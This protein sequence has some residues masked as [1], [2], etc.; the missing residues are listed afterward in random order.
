MPATMSESSTPTTHAP[1]IAFVGGGSGGH[2]SPGLAIDEALRARSATVR[3]VFI[4][5]DRA[6]DET[7]LGAA[8]AARFPV[9]ARPPSIRP[10]AAWRFVRAWST[11]RSRVTDILR[12][13]SATAVVALGGFVAAPA[14]AAAR[15]LK[16]PVLLL[17]L[18]APP[19][20]A[21]RWIA[22]Q[23]TTTWT[24][25]DLPAHP[26]FAARTVGVP[27]RTVA[28]A[29]DDPAACRARLGLDP[30]RP[31]LLIT[32]ASQGARSINAFIAR[33]IETRASTLDGWSVLH[34]CGQDADHEALRLGYADAGVT[35]AVY[36]FLHTIGDAWGAA[37]L[38]IS[39]AGANSV[40]EIHANAVPTVFLP[41]PYH[42][43]EHQRH[44][45]EPLV[46]RGGAVMATDHIDPDANVADAG[47][48]V[49]TLLTEPEQR[50]AMRT[51]MLDHPPLDAADAVARHLL[52]T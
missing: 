25:P 2:L 48:L 24:A 45:A 17:N 11:S 7:M 20:R 51:I 19:G 47:E 13:E 31:V 43:D 30:D 50:A 52:G 15:R 5:S 27:L 42:K 32:G 35:A 41:Y 9:A 28:R 44:N 21:N 36:P 46:Q 34:L 3:T 12:A 4:C 18:D 39:R 14:V 8:G 29:T 10:K 40:A 6:V 49:C 22:R 23:A 16:L 33:L 37:S 1:T 26:R 38:A